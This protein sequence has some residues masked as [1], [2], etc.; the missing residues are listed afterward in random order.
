M[1]EDVFR[2]VILA[3]VVLACF[4][5]I[6]QAGVALALYRVARKV[7]TRI[8]PLADRADSLLGATHKL[9][10][11][12]RP[13]ISEISTQAVEIARS[14]RAQADRMSELLED[15]AERVR[16][17]LAQLDQSVGDAVGQVED[18][19]GAV[20]SAV[21]KPVKEV[22]GVMAAMKAAVSAYV[23]AGRRSSIEHATQD[24]EMFI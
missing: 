8:E 18:V 12:N 17:R 7:Q 21:L 20:R 23:N 14:T 4:A 19:G 16:V 1:S 13:R 6:V 9:L 15:T 11:E 22:N 24:E 2:W 10:E 5:F 3:A